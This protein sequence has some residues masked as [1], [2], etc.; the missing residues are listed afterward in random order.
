MACGPKG[1]HGIDTRN[2]N[3]TWTINALSN[4]P[5][6]GYAEIESTP[7]ISLVPVSGA[8]EIFIV[9]PFSGQVVFNSK[10]AGINNIASRFVLPENNALVVVGQKPDRSAAM[11]CVDMGTGKVRW[12]KDDAFS[13]LTSCNSAGK[14]AILLSTLFFAYKLDANTGAELWKKSPDPSFEK[15][16]GLT[17]MLDKG[18]ANLK[19]MDDVRGIFITTPYAPELCYMGMQTVQRK[20]TT[21]SQGKTSVSI[22]YKTFINAFQISDGTYAW[23]Q[24]LIMQQQLGTIVPLQQG[25]LVGAADR[26]S[27]DLLDYRSGNGLWGK[28]GGGISV[29]GTLNGAVPMDDGV[30]LVS[31]GKD[32]SAMMVDAQGMERW[33]KPVKLGGTI[34][35]VTVLSNAI[36][37]S[38]DEET[39]LVD[40]AIGTSKLDRPIKGGSDLVATAEGSTF[41]FNTKDGL[42]HMMPESGGNIKALTSTPIEFEGKERPQQIEIIPE[43]ILLSSD[44]N[45]ALIGRDGSIKYKKYFP[46][47]RES[48]LT[49]ALKYASAVR[50]AYY[51]A[52]FGYTSA[53][54]GAVSQNIKVQDTE[55][56]VARQMTGDLSTIFGDATR[57]GTAATSRFLEEANLRLKATSSTDDVHFMMTD[58]GKRQYQ[59]IALRKSDGSVIGSIPLGS[60]KTPLYEVDAITNTVY[61]AL[62]GDLKAFTVE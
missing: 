6:S 53:A 28:K 56:A 48:G 46:A 23:Q 2:G 43:G 61:L 27:A 15:M 40:R 39:D 14:D 54:F 55:S 24:P 3:I 34:R 4:A 13:R 52:L 7:Y 50:A 51:T 20:E 47:G 45:V 33:K 17:S 22:T 32:G 18:G 16:S 62:D 36:M 59:L 10:E 37:I 8:D 5:A 41:L 57:Q 35:S 42:L 9:E 38:S 1:L 25:L 60:E 30:L 19:G 58:G 21:D 31:G 11:A 12:T 44:Q 26:N 29:K 49:R